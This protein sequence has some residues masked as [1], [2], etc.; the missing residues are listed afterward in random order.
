MVLSSV[1]LA[2]RVEMSAL[3]G[4]DVGVVLEGGHLDLVLEVGRAVVREGVSLPGVDEVGGDQGIAVAP[5]DA[6][7]QVEGVRQLVVG[8]LVGLAEAVLDLAV[9]V[10]DEEALDAVADDGH[11]DPRRRRRWGRARRRR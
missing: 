3:P 7:A 9:G 2:P 5:G 4:D 1:A 10:L 8:D 6:V 11:G